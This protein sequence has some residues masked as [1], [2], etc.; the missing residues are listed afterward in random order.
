MRVSLQAT[1]IKVIEI[2]PPAVRTELHDEIHQPDIKNG[3]S[4]GMPLDEF[5][6]AVRSLRHVVADSMLTMDRPGLDSAKATRTYL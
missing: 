6:E 4:M 3:R 5:T 2:Y 1:E